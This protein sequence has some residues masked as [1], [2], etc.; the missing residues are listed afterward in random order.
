MDR[1]N[2]EG[3]RRVFADNI[4]K[5][6]EQRNLTQKQMADLLE[7]SVSSI[8]MWQAGEREVDFFTLKLIAD[9]FDI[10]IDALLGRSSELP[11]NKKLIIE[12]GRVVGYIVL[13]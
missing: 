2:K 6:R 13:Y 11:Q 3:I 4:K 9:T 8:A 10:T 12:D 7:V 1:S 5:L